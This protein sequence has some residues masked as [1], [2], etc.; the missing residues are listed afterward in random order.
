[1]HVYGMSLF[2]KSFVHVYAKVSFWI[3]QVMSP[4]QLHPFSTISFKLFNMFYIVGVKRSNCQ[5]G[6]WKHR[7]PTRNS[8]LLHVYQNFRSASIIEVGVVLCIYPM[9]LKTAIIE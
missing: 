7:Y 1:M 4:L 8:K 2:L 3:I 9:F 6:S 5:K